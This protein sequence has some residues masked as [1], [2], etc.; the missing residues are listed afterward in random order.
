MVIEPVT[1]FAER[2]AQEERERAHRRR[3]GLA[4]QSSDLNSPEVRIRA[5]EKLHGLRLPSDP[6][7]PI[8]DVVAISTHLT[9]A[10]VQDEQRARSSRTDA[11]AP[12][13]PPDHYGSI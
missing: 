9:L 3:Q 4:E 6:A 5:W 8:L 11:A 7:H 2:Q 13:P 1:T 10:Q 12:T